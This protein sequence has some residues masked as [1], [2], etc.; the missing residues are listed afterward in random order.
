MIF[1]SLTHFNFFFII[2]FSSSFFVA[3]IWAM[4]WHLISSW[5]RFHVNVH[6]SSISTILNFQFSNFL[7][8]SNFSALIICICFL[9]ATFIQILEEGEKDDVATLLSVALE[10]AL[11][12]FLSSK[13]FRKYSFFNTS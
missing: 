3:I 9:A 11:E 7:I 10:A 5:A 13:F 8:K 2:E 1:K 4:R 12:Y 6:F